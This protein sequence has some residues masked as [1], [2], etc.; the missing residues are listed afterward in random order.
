[1]LLY[2]RTGDFAKTF[3]APPIIGL[4]KEEEAWYGKYNITR[5]M[6]TKNSFAMKAIISQLEVEDHGGIGLFWGTPTAVAMIN[7]KKYDDELQVYRILKETCKYVRVCIGNRES[8]IKAQAKREDWC[9]YGDV[10]PLDIR[11]GICTPKILNNTI[12]YFADRHPKIPIKVIISDSGSWNGYDDYQTVAIQLTK[13]YPNICIMGVV[14]RFVSINVIY[15][16]DGKTTFITNSGNTK[17][18]L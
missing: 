16:R 2:A 9:L 6:P 14:I 17:D 3:K 12:I 1:M 11:V 5:G 10:R 8:K 13:K 18:I 7:G 15:V 4:R